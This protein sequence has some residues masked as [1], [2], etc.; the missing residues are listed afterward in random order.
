MSEPVNVPLFILLLS[1]QLSSSKYVTVRPRYHGGLQYSESSFV[2]TMV[3]IIPDLLQCTEK[4]NTLS[5][6][7]FPPSYFHIAYINKLH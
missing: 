3:Q 6:V 4:K 5:T 7:I 2:M 1:T